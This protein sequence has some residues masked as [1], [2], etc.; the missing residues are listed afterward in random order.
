[1]SIHQCPGVKITFDPWNGIND[2]EHNT[3]IFSLSSDEYAKEYQK[4]LDK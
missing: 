3:R 4:N 2:A 1:M